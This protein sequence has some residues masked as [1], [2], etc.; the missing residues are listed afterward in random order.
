MKKISDNLTRFTAR[1]SRIFEEQASMSTVNF[2][3]VTV[4]KYRINEQYI[5]AIRRK[6]EPEH[7]AWRN[8]E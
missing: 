7:V 6:R 4:R 3:L 1:I 2:T 8:T 5:G